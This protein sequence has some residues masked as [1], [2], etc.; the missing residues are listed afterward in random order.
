MRTSGI[1]SRSFGASS[2][3]RV[4]IEARNPATSDGALL[5]FAGNGEFEKRN[6]MYCLNINHLSQQLP[7]LQLHF[8]KHYIG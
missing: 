3:A 4:A 7:L 2:F 6:Q 8:V 1:S 5:P